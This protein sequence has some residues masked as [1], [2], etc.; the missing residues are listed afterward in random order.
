LSLHSP[1]Q[2]RHFLRL[3]F[4]PPRPGPFNYANEVL[5]FCF[6]IFVVVVVAV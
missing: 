4:V 1:I 6:F 3:Q 5:S 2:C